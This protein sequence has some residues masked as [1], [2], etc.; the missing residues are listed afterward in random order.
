MD[1]EISDLVKKMDFTSI[2]SV[3][4]NSGEQR[5]SSRLKHGSMSQASDSDSTVE[6]NKLLVR[7]SKSENRD[8]FEYAEDKTMLPTYEINR[9][10]DLR[11]LILNKKPAAKDF[12]DRENLLPTNER[13]SSSAN[14]N[15]HWLLA[16]H[17]EA[18]VLP[19]RPHPNFPRHLPEC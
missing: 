2:P 19:C 16:T 13:N 7:A 17:Q 8:P 10:S 15:S 14:R 1:S 9:S 11:A 3:Q 6:T 5:R 12:L 18:T 4:E